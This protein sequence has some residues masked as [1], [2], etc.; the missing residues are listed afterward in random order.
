MHSY[1]EDRLAAVFS[2]D[3]GRFVKAESLALAALRKA[4]ITG[5]LPPGQ[6]IDEEM[7]AKHLHI[8]RMPVRQAMA[9]LES[10]GLVI[11]AYKR[12]VT[13][14]ELSAAEI[15]EIYHMR[16]SLESLAISRA[17]P[18]YT[19]PHLDEVEAVLQELK[20]SDRSDIGSFVDVNTKFHSLLYEPS[21]WDT[22]CS[23]I[24]KL[25]NNIAR[26]VWISHHFIQE[27]PNMGADHD[28]ILEACRRRDAPTA[29]ALT[30]QHIF[31]AMTTLLKSFETN[32][33][34]SDITDGK[35]TASGSGG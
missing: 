30:R 12:G 24:I 26:Y 9:T 22:L 19:D 20:E 32:A 23:L 27:L 11:R 5:A 28:K 21:N 33:W 25:R 1:D 7:I 2:S 34:I 14:T 15:E 4:I 8:S 31:N 18:N 16:A 10:E 35:A 13:V 6:A 3:F 29:E 17:V